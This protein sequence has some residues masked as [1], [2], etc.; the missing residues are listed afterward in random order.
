MEIR[1]EFSYPDDR[2]VS[3]PMEIEGRERLIVF[4]A[5]PNA[6]GGRTVYPK[7]VSEGEVAAIRAQLA[8]ESAERRH[9]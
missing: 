1:R 7:S 3:E 5:A 6:R 2:Q 8:A 9:G 4:V